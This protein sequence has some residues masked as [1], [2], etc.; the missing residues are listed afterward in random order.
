MPQAVTVFIGCVDPRIQETLDRLRLNLG[1]EYGSFFRVLVQGGAGN[2]RQLR[3]H[4][5]LVLS[6]YR[7][8]MVSVVLTTHEDCRAGVTKE[9]LLEATRIVREEFGLTEVQAFYILLNG[10]WESLSLSPEGSL[11]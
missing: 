6:D 4:L 11:K 8:Q 5:S 1:L 10:S 2:S 7:H 9:S 3:E